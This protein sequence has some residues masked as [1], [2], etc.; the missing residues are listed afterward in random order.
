MFNVEIQ[1]DN[2]KWFIAEGGAN[3]TPEA[4]DEMIIALRK[5]GFR[6]RGVFA[7]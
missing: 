6:A 5:Q 3:L 1:A 4:A 7:D 2:G